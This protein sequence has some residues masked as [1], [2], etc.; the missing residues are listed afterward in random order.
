VTS[1]LHGKVAKGLTVLRQANDP[2]F[3][4]VTPSSLPTNA[5]PEP[6]FV[7]LSLFAR[8]SGSTNAGPVYLSLEWSEQSQNWVLSQMYSDVLL[9]MHVMF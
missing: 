1:L 3:R 5:S 9:N 8:S 7:H 2:G 4:Y 6:V